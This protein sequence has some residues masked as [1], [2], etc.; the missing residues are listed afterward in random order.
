MPIFEYRCEVCD[1]DFEA[2]VS[3]SENATCPACDGKRLQRKLSVF[4]VGG[5]TRPCD[6]SP[7]A[8]DCGSCGDPR[9]PGACGLG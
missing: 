7:S 8:G 3:A 4:A 2:I 5:G 9:G 1:L 6:T